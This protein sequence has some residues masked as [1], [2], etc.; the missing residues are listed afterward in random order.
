M[1]VT[2]SGKSSVMAPLARLLHAETAEG[3]AF[4]SAANIGKMSSG[5]PLTDEDRLP[6]LR[7]IA[8]WIGA[9]EGD[10]VAAVVPCSAL[11]RR[12]RDIL[13]D[14]HPSVVFV[15]LVVPTAVLADRLEARAGHYMPPS[16]LASQLE[17]LEPLG[18]DEPGFELPAADRDPDDV[19]AEIASRLDARA[20]PDDGG[21]RR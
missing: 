21:D 12:Y 1:G 20:D 17:T 15:H 3:D 5:T 6:W 14:G 10:G 19:A 4:H 9:R 11:R 7:S 2:G 8:D 16:L 13:R 18:A